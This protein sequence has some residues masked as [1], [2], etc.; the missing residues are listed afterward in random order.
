VDEEEEE[1][2]ASAGRHT[3]SNEG[4]DGTEAR[5]R[6]VRRDSSARDDDDDEIDD[7][8]RR[9]RVHDPPVGSP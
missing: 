1:S 4:T 3:R 5:A 2:D 6:G 8:R 9:R 7:G